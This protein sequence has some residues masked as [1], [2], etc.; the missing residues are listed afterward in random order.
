MD[1][2]PPLEPEISDFV[3]EVLLPGGPSHQPRIDEAACRFRLQLAP[4]RIHRWGVYADEAIPARRRVIE[5]TGQRIG[6]REAYRRRLR[7]QLYLFRCSERK[8][9]DGGIGGSGAE[10][11]NH[12][13]APNL[14]ARFDHR[15]V[16]YSSLR[17]IARGQE[18]LIDYHVRGDIAPIACHCG[19]AECR[20]FLN[21]PDP[22]D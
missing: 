6:L 2:S 16:F 17:P 19:A 12:G 10:F 22:A 8:L 20:G 11:I 21:E 1:G 18:L 7:P 15:R 5:Y 4:S 13:C 3:R 14:I 9:I